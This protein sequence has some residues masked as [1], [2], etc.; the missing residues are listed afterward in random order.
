MDPHIFRNLLFLTA[1]SACYIRM[2]GT[3]SHT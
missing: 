2:N 3:V 1:V